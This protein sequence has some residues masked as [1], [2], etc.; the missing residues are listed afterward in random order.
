[1]SIHTVVPQDCH[2]HRTTIVAEHLPTYGSTWYH[3]NQESTHPWRDASMTHLTIPSED[4]T[5]THFA[6]SCMHT[7]MCVRTS[8]KAFSISS[9]SSCVALGHRSAYVHKKSLT[10]LV[11]LTHVRMQKSWHCPTCISR[12]NYSIDS[13]EAHSCVC[14]YNK[15]L[16]STTAASYTSGCR[17]FEL[18]ELQWQLAHKIHYF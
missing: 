3:T 8:L 9:F 13:V 4:I 17:T 7:L 11:F 2:E 15:N 18:H 12:C 10:M 5:V 14:W 1:M 6:H 16:M